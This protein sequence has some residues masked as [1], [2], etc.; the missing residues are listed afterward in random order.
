M[1]ETLAA[2]F[3]TDRFLDVKCD[4]AECARCDGTVPKPA[5]HSDGALP[6]LRIAGE[7]SRLRVRLPRTPREEGG[8]SHHLF[9]SPHHPASTVLQQKLEKRLP[10]IKCSADMEAC[11][12]ML[13]V[14][15]AGASGDA[16][17][18]S[19]A[20]GNEGYRRDILR[21]LNS[22]VGIVSL[23]VGSTRLEAYASGSARGIPLWKAGLYD[24]I[25]I[26]APEA[27]L[28]PAAA[29]NAAREDSELE[30]I[31]LGRVGLKICASVPPCSRARPLRSVARPNKDAA[32]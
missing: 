7:A 20:L 21:A 8:A 17:A 4:S 11:S 13:V 27:V 22:G 12:L 32:P 18:S 26:P 14:L 24:T 28:L 25:A 19:P 30:A 6:A 3:D 1:Q 9:V 5:A 16:E 23:L 15:D 2:S 29:P 31:A 10:G